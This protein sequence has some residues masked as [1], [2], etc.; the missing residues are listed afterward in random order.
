[1]GQVC[2]EATVCQSHL[3]AHKNLHGWTLPPEVLILHVGV[4]PMV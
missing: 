3:G 1:M 4:G 2:L